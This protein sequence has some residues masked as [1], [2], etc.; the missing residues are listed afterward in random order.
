M[1]TA[2]PPLPDSPSIAPSPSNGKAKD[3]TTT[4]AAKADIRGNTSN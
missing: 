1:D 3:T 2:E 4:N